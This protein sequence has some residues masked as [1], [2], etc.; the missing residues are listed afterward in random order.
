[1]RDTEVETWSAEDNFSVYIKY[2]YYALEYI[3]ITNFQW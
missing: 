1:M 2:V 3:Q